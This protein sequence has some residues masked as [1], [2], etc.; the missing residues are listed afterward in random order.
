[1]N[2]PENDLAELM[3]K[4]H[5]LIGR[6]RH[7]QVEK[8]FTT[9]GTDI[10]QGALATGILIKGCKLKLVAEFHPIDDKEKPLEISLGGQ[11][12]AVNMDVVSGMGKQRVDADF[13]NKPA[14]PLI[15]GD[16]NNDGKG[17]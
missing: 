10:V 9:L 15:L 11:E 7:P 5:K 4:L 13:A 1:M 17:H 8:F 14:S 16:H 3:V 6:P 12:V 2:I